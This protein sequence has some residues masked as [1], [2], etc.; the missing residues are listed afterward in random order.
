MSP[1]YSNNIKCSGKRYLAFKEHIKDVF[2]RFQNSHG[3]RP[4]DIIAL[5]DVPPHVK[6]SGIPGYR[7]ECHSNKELAPHHTAYLSNYG[8][9][10]RTQTEKRGL[11]IAAKE[12]A[13][14]MARAKERNS[15]SNRAF[16]STD[17]SV[18]RERGQHC[19]AIR[20][21]IGMDHVAFFI[22]N[23]IPA[24]DCRFERSVQYPGLITTLHLTTR[25]G[26]FRFHNIYNHMTDMKPKILDEHHMSSKADV[27][28][29]DTNL[30][31]RFWGGKDVRN[32]SRD[33]RELG[34]YAEKRMYNPLKKGTITY[35]RGIREDSRKFNYRTAVDV[36]WVS[37][38]ISTRAISCWMVDARGL[39]AD[40]GIIRLE[41][42]VQPNRL[43][44][45]VRYNPDLAD[46][47]LLEQFA[48]EEFSKIE[49]P[50]ELTPSMVR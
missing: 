8:N 23:T 16:G 15:A 40:H 41:L 30:H 28:L 21:V 24:G 32:V 36:A 29:G 27:F 47:D 3:P 7:L 35:A 11:K 44:Q 42:D 1:V 13:L 50:E 26:V 20:D 38:E 10:G 6:M 46:K 4:P 39:E 19:H 45:R 48:I 33:G 12:L 31:H 14:A 49:M 34:R 17:E 37:R 43:A 22:R 5:Q 25:A 9:Q 2:R 18:D